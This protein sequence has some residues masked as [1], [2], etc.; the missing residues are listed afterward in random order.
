MTSGSLW[1]YYRDEVDDVN[2]TAS[3]GKSFTYKAKITEKTQERPAQPGNG[4]DADQ[5]ARPPVPTLNV[6]IN[7]P[8]NHLN[9]FW[10]YLDLPLINCD[11]LWTKD[12]GL[13]QHHNNI[14][15]VDF[16]IASTK[17]YLPVVA[18]SINDNIKFLEKLK[19]EFKRSMFWNKYRSEKT[20]QPKDINLV[21]MIVMQRSGT[22]IDCLFDRSKLVKMIPQEFLL[23]IT[24]H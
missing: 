20:T 18:L 5:P 10:K 12:C 11:L 21:Y 3:N 6:E 24:C 19:Q 22:L 17:P 13:I 14:A 4:G 9:N 1:N 2:N 8:L 16:V 23:T 15:G 7:V